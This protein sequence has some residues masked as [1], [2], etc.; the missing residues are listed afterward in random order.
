MLRVFLLNLE[1]FLPFAKMLYDFI[2]F[3]VIAFWLVGKCWRVLMGTTNF[4]YII[5]DCLQVWASHLKLLLSS[6]HSLIHFLANWETNNTAPSLLSILSVFST[7]SWSNWFRRKSDSHL[8]VDLP[9]QAS[10][11]LPS[12]L[13]ITA[14]WARIAESSYGWET[15]YRS[16]RI[17]ET[18]CVRASK[19]LKNTNKFLLSGLR[20]LYRASTLIRMSLHYLTIFQSL[21]HELIFLSI[22]ARYPVSSIAASSLVGRSRKIDTPCSLW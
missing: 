12:S 20:E 8:V 19:R 21:L 6:S 22:A 16:I 1:N 18:S 7:M 15:S 3:D 4:R 10:A 5:F 13:E 14:K 9:F 2:L 11:N 17:S